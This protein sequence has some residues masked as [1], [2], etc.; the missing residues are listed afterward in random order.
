M[1]FEYILNFPN[2]LEQGI[3]IY[4]RSKIKLDSNQIHNIVITG[5]GGSGIGGT[6]V[7]EY[8]LPFSKIPVFVN[9][10][11]QLPAFVNENT[12]V[13]ASSYSGNTEETLQCVEQALK[14]KSHLVA[15]TSGGKL[16]ELAREYR[17]PVILLPKGFPP[18][19]C[20]GYSFVQI[21]GIFEKVGIINGDWKEKIYV[22]AKLLR[23][24]QNHIREKAQDIAQK[25]F[26]TFP[27]I[28]S[29]HS[30]ALAWRLR[31]QLNENSKVLCSYHII[32]EMNHNEIV[33]WRVLNA[34]HSVLVFL[35]SADLEQNRK[36]YF[37]C[38]K[39][40]ENY[41][42][43][44]IELKGMG[45]SLLEEWMYLVHLSDWIS[46]E[47]AV[48]NNVDAVEVKVIDELKGYLSR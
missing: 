40:F 36:R 24:E 38:K 32:P 45:D 48:L 35:T 11:Y 19:T 7:A 47:L 42:V 17:F 23:E 20:L 5:M 29:L 21:L 44:L 39:I 9:K 14:Q 43:P 12:L 37:F 46:Y 16:E 15:I 13:I 10:S 6:F 33:G 25:I 1:M 26:K 30:E 22:S 2:Q 41:K 34:A 3:D 31:Q 18:R 28:Y 4:E 27:I 8:V